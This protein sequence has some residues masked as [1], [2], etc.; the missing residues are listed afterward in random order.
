MLNSLIGGSKTSDHL[1]GKA[2]DITD[3]KISNKDLYRLIFE[4]LKEN[5]IKFKQFIYEY[6]TN[7]VHI[8]Y[9]MNNN[10]C[11]YMYRYKDSKGGLIYKYI[12]NISKLK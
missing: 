9:D 6:D 11:E 10:K 12:D 2:A 1:Y 8:S 7:C 5:N 4:Y 3:K